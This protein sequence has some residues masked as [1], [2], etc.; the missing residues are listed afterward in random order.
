MKTAFVL[1]G[2]GAKGAFQVGVMEYLLET[3]VTPEALY[4]TS[5]GALNSAGYAFQGMAGLKNLWLGIKKKSDIIESNW[6][7]FLTK[8]GLYT[9]KPLKKL[10]DQTIDG[11]PGREA[12][13]TYVDLEDGQLHY[14]KASEESLQEFRKHTLASASI[15]FV[16]DPVD[17][18][19]VDGGVREITPL[20]RAI[21]EGADKI[22]VILASPYKYLLPKGWNRAWPV[23]LFVGLRSL[24]IIEQEV[25]WNDINKC[26]E[27]NK[28]SDKKKIELELYAPNKPVLDTLDFEPKKIRAGIEQGFR[29]RNL[30]V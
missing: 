29:A 28:R 26:L 14:S 7:H 3:G 10:L 5:V 6:Y 4:G 24:E 22:V 13:V 19:Y 27:Y 2:G 30:L 12:T 17:K 18:R 1:S 20:K 9:T 16:M 25:F 8:G 21:K 15:P 11:T 23:P